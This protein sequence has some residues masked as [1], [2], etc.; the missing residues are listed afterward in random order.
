MYKY[1]S[2]HAHGADGIIPTIHVLCESDDDQNSID[3][4]CKKEMSQVSI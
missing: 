3:S 2:T 1:Q 4:L